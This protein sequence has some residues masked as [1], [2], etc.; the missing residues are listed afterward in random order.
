[1]NRSKN[2]RYPVCDEV[3]DGRGRPERMRWTMPCYAD[4][5]GLRGAALGRWIGDLVWLV[6]VR[7]SNAGIWVMLG[8]IRDVERRRFP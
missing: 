2:G 7:L 8:A 4:C 3:T 1:M 6:E 5:L